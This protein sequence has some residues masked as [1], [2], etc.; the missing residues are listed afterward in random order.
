MPT[1]RTPLNRRQKSY[2][3]HE[4]VELFE[5]CDAIEEAGFDD[6]WEQEGGRRREYLN[7]W[8]K[9]NEIL[10]VR[11]WEY[12]PVVACCPDPPDW[13]NKKFWAEGWELRCLLDDETRKG[14]LRNP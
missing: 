13:A 3:T 4:A 8:F 5:L 11:S 10:H 7:A 12:G 14:P 9:L 6:I 1:R 2:I